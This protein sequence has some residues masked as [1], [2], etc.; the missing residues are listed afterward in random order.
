MFLLR[1]EHSIESFFDLAAKELIALVKSATKQTQRGL[2]HITAER[3]PDSPRS[4][5]RPE[6]VATARGFPVTQ[7]DWR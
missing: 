3:H 5:R 2:F 6:S 1:V 7:A 4:H